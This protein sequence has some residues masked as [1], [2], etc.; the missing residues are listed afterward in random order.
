MP[1]ARSVANSRKQLDL[2]NQE[3][4]LLTATNLEQRQR[5][6]Q[7]LTVYL[8]DTGRQQTDLAK[9][10]GVAD[11]TI[12][13]W[14]NLR[15]YPDEKNRKKL[16]IAIGYTFARLEAELEGK[17]LG[18]KPE[19]TLAQAKEFIRLCSPKDFKELWSDVIVL[20]VAKALT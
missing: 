7:I 18:G 19:L 2:L 5:L 6:R 15:Q 9:A 20:R 10:C 12:S 13:A 16:A 3:K 1:T 11:T 14:L 17:T 8:R 4:N